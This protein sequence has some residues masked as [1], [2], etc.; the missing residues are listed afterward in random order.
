MKQITLDSFYYPKSTLDSVSA[1]NQ[2]YPSPKYYPFPEPKNT[3]RLNPLVLPSLQKMDIDDLQD[4]FGKGFQDKKKSILGEKLE[5][6]KL[7]KE[8]LEIQE[9]KSSIE[10]AKLNQMRAFQMQQNHMRRIQNLIKDTQADEEVLKKLKLDKIKAK[11]EEERKKKERIKAKHLIQQQMIEKEKL[12]EE[13]KKEYEKD[14]KDMQNLVKN[15]KNEDMERQ[16]EEQR[17]KDI[18]KKYMETAYAEKEE[19]KRREKEEDRKQ[20]ERERQ[21]QANLAERENAFN[22]KK[23]EIQ[24]EKDKIFEKLCKEEAKRQAER[25]YWENIRNELHLEQENRREKLKELAEKE[26]LQ[27][28]K[29]EMLN[30][31]IQQRKEKEEN[32]KKEKEMEEEFKKKLMEKFDEEEKLEMLTLKKRK[33]KET[34]M[35]EEIERQWQLKL[36]QYQKQKEAEL[37]ELLKNKKEEERKSYLID[38]EKKRLIQENERL[39]QKYYPFGYK[40]AIN[41]LKNF[42]SPKNDILAKKGIIY[43]N[44]FGNSNPNEASSYPKYGKIKNFVY[45]KAIQDVHPR[46]NKINYPMYNATANNDYDSYPSPEEYKKMMDKTGQLNYAYAGGGDT[47]GIPLRSQMAT[48]SNNCKRLRRIGRRDNNMQF[49]NF[50]TTGTNYYNNSFKELNTTDGFQNNYNS[51]ETG[52]KN[53]TKLYKTDKMFYQRQ[54][55]VSPLNRNLIM[56][57]TNPNGIHSPNNYQQTIDPNM[58]S[59]VLE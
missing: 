23:A 42:P 13:A 35:K 11:E 22:D 48:F 2:P 55:S 20:K 40:R 39:L 10:Y 41:S 49:S 18:A 52:F 7:F 4:V 56:R 57:S 14:M 5:N 43:N 16:K 45:D 44:I 21:Y 37:N 24:S 50:N 47:T 59:K 33:E 26:K 51:N 29:E 8:S 53:W 19:R 25:D 28:Q 32:K 6:A 31:A 46:I 9:I 1:Q 30:S 38:Q 27:R 58:A 34:E 17:K 54:K 15:L 3:F 36:K 12:K